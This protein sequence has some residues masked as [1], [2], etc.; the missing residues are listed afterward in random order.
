MAIGPAIMRIETNGFGVI[1]DGLF[2]VIMALMDLA[3]AK[4]G[5]RRGRIETHRRVKIP[6]RVGVGPLLHVDL[7]PPNV[8]PCTLRLASNGGLKISD[9]PVVFLSLEISETA[10]VVSLRAIRGQT[11]RPAEFADGRIVLS[12]A[13]PVQPALEM[14]RC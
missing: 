14:I 10:L 5:G 6:E 12:L 13:S 7:A 1:G 11:Q 3:A 9:G 2:M 4:I 8:G